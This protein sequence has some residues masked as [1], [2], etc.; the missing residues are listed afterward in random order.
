MPSSTIE[1]GSI[2]NT[3]LAFSE[4]ALFT[5]SSIHFL[6]PSKIKDCVWAFQFDDDEPVVFATSF[7]EGQNQL[8]FVIDN[9]TTGSIEFNGLDGKKLKIFAKENK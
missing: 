6:Q 8:T 3:E 9:S 2:I 7:D 1:A 5:S 4:T